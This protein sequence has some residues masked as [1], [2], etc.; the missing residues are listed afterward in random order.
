MK[1][2]I[3]KGNDDMITLG[4][5]IGII[6]AVVSGIGSLVKKKE[7]EKRQD[8]VIDRKIKERLETK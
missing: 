5:I 8:E 6:G 3:K 4:V 2:S 1:I 7:E